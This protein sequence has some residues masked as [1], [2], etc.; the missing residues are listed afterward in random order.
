DPARAAGVGDAERAFLARLRFL[1]R[2]MPELDLAA[3]GDAF[4]ADAIA[5][6][7]DGKRSFAELRQADLL[8][9]L[10]GL[11]THRQRGALAREAP[12]GFTLP[13]GRSVPIAYEPDRPPSFAARIQEVFGLRATPR[14]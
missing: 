8:G 1:Q 6:L 5:A 2:A 12:T 4:L 11:L 7:C 10:Q 9:V 3:D 14:L 13:T